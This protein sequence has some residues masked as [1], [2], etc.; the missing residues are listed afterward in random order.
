MQEACCLVQCG[1][2]HG[3][4][5]IHMADGAV[6]NSN[7]ESIPSTLRAACSTRAPISSAS[8]C[9]RNFCR[10]SVDSQ[11]DTWPYTHLQPFNRQAVLTNRVPVSRCQL[12]CVGYPDLGLCLNASGR[13]STGAS[14]EGRGKADHQEHC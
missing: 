12:S 10:S 14:N 7:N 4:P 6:E 5:Y 9:A 13:W 11:L 8:A 1:T 2:E 3:S